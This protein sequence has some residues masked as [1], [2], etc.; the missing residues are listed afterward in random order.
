NCEAD[1]IHARG[2]DAGRFIVGDVPRHDDERHVAIGEVVVAVVRPLVDVLGRQ[3]EHVAIEHRHVVGVHRAHRH[4]VDMAGIGLA[5]VVG[6]GRGGG[7]GGLFWEGGQGGLGGGGGGGG[8]R[9]VGWGRGRVF[10]EGGP[11][12]AFA[13]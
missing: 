3:F 8:G 4:V 9:P 6:L 1:V 2:D 13:H 7:W 11:S 10:R 5:V 12:A